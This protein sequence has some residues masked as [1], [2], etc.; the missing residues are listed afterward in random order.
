MPRVVSMT[1][2]VEVM[3][4]ETVVT[5]VGVV[6]VDISSE[7]TNSHLSVGVCFLTNQDGARRRAV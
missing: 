4:I 6:N 2:A 1:H 5:G 7:Q 3:V